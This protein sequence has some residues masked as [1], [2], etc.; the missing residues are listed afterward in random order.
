MAISHNA[1][2][3]NINGSSYFNLFS[4][5]L[6]IR[7]NNALTSIDGFENLFSIGDGPTMGLYIYNNPVLTSV[8][9]LS[10]LVQVEGELRISNN[11]VLTNLDG[12][13]GLSRVA[14]KLQIFDNASL[15][16][17]DWLP[18][19]VT[20]G[21]DLNIY[22]NGVLPQCEACDLLAQ[23]IQYSGTYSFHDNQPDTCSDNCD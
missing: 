16:D 23:L 19:L 11:P 9:G 4:S 8:N 13:N 15:A 20:V 2:L 7:D 18:I 22:N 14:W 5:D 1:S 21:G 6:H 17:I 10:D 12:L 3:V